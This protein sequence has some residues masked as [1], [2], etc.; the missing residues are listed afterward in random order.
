MLPDGHEK[1]PTEALIT[2]LRSYQSTS[3]YARVGGALDEACN[4]DRPRF[5]AALLGHTLSG[6]ST[7]GLLEASVAAFLTDVAAAAD[8]AASGGAV[9]ELYSSALVAT[10][11]WL[12]RRLRESAEDSL[13]APAEVRRPGVPSLQC[14]WPAR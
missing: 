14:S 2:A 8:A 12:E 13:I 1:S 7:H 3:D 11:T 10:Q 9:G 5:D 4:V 6:V